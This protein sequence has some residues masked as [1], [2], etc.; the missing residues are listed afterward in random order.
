MTQLPEDIIDRLAQMDRRVR[1]LAK[2]VGVRRAITTIGGTAIRIL[3]GNGATILA[4]AAAGGLSRP[5]LT[6]LPPQEAD[7]TRWPQTNATVWTRIAHSSNVVWQPNLRLVLATYAAASTAGQIQVLV[8][9]VPFGPVVT[10]GSSFD[11]SGPVAGSGDFKDMF[12]TVLDF[13]IQAQV[14]SGTGAVYA[15]PQLMYGFES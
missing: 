2:A 1:Q 6:M 10:A 15:Q 7:H 14:T 3:D 9:G 5:W 4:D 11:Y 8:G 12:G 13:E